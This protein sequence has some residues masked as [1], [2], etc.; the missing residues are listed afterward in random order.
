MTTTKT[1]RTVRTKVYKFAG[2]SKEAKEKAVENILETIYNYGYNW[3]DEAHESIKR[4]CEAFGLT[5]KSSNFSPYAEAD[6]RDSQIDDNILELS[7][8]RLR[9]Y[10]LNNYYHLLYDRKHYGELRKTES[11]KY[12]YQRYSRCQWKQT[13]CQFTGYCM[14]DSLLFP[15]R[16][17]V[18]KPSNLTFAELMEECISEWVKDASSDCKEQESYE[19]LAEHIEANEYEFLKDGTRSPF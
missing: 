13:E 6:V 10:I 19:Y 12:K 5:Y 7:G 15:I 18:S 16:Q 2:L 14:D 11:G 1:S 4:F 17:F 3:A 9:T 8:V